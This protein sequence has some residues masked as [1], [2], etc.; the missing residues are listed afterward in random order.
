MTIPL[1]GTPEWVEWRKGGIGASELP[2]IVGANP[3]QSEYE[4]A[5]LKRG[6]TE[7]E[8]N[9]A[10]GWGHRVQRLALE[11]YGEMTGHKVRNVNTTT[12]SKQ[13]PHVY[14]S[15][16]GRV[17]GERRGVEIKL[18]RAW[19]EPP[20]RVVIQCQ[21]Q[22]GVCNLD[23]IDVV[24]VGMGYSE[25]GIYTLERDDALIDGLLELA[26]AW[27]LR[28]VVG[29][30]YPP[31]DGSKGASRHLDNLR[32]D[33]ERAANDQ[34]V[35]LLDSL[36]A[37]RARLAEDER[38]DKLIV[39]ELKNTMADTGILTAPNARVTW[40]ATK[41]RTTTDWHKVAQMLK[42]EMP[43]EQFDALAERHT[44]TGDPSTRFA[45]RF[46]EE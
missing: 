40:A 37:V 26:E 14:A 11:L 13:Y 33:E 20:R 29:D 46:E 30:E 15:L 25:P 36:R 27:Y 7:T 42:G 43:A 12:T 34:Q 38:T 4:L 41:G 17:V 19:E 8:T 16:D 23:A 24:R 1:Q 44:T 3:Y 31:V 28:Y 2:S 18:T 5:L 35:Q 10:M 9:A 22:M 32:G 21:A 45:V 6:E 39:N